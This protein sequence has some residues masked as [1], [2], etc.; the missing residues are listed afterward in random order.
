MCVR[1][2]VNSEVCAPVVP[3]VDAFASQRMQ[4]NVEARKV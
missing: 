1:D 3:A 4:Q 2:R